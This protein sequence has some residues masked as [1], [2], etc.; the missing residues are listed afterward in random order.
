MKRPS[1]RPIVRVT[2]LGLA[3]LFAV[4][5]LVLLILGGP[6]TAEWGAPGAT[7]AWGLTFAVIGYV[8]DRSQPQNPIGRLMQVA[9]IGAS[10]LEMLYRF[11]T[12][13]GETSV[14]AAARVATVAPS[15]MWMIPVAALFHSL[16]IFPDGK[17]L[18]RRWR[19]PVAG[20]WTAAALSF[21]GFFFGPS[22]VPGVSN[23][24]QVEA[25][26]A[27][28]MAMQFLSYLIFQFSSLLVVV[29]LVIRFRH[30][31]GERRLQMK[32]VVYATAITGATILVV[33]VILRLFVPAWYQGGSWFVSLVV[34]SISAAIGIAIMR[35]RLYA[36]DRL[37]SRTVSYGL[38]I[39]LSALVYLTG[40][41]LFR[42]I[43]P[44][45]SDLAVA[46]S[47]LAVAAIFQPARRRLQ[48]AVDRRFNRARYDAEQVVASFAAHLRSQVEL[49]TV[50]GG[51]T[52]VVAQT[53][54]PASASVWIR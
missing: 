52:G 26:D 15:W 33:E 25:L 40:I 31:T 42:A 53:V 29:E 51:L 7:L 48:D 41:F 39:G 16:A 50:T 44:L 1:G 32:W 21:L 37:V 8:I 13:F 12:F 43:L 18:S 5:A 19:N 14:S 47:T 24:L 27:A 34:L 20:L 30:V 11:G 4:P 3:G 22:D 46:G 6:E 23:P 49:G 2:L 45:E 38:V 17:H 28:T 9:G 54:Q 35:Y 36:I 10:A